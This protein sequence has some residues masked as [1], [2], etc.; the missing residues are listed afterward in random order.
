MSSVTD[1][2]QEIQNQK[3]LLSTKLDVNKWIFL[4]QG[5]GFVDWAKHI[6]NLRFSGHPTDMAHETLAKKILAKIHD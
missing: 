6:L 4:D 2:S 1:L 5:L 3:N